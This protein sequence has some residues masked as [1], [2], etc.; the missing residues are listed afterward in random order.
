MLTVTSRVS[1]KATIHRS[2]KPVTLP[3]RIRDSL[4]SGSDRERMQAAVGLMRLAEAAQL[5]AEAAEATHASQP[6]NDG[7]NPADKMGATNES[8]DAASIEEL[9][10]LEEAT[11][12]QYDRIVS[13]LKK[14]KEHEHLPSDAGNSDSNVAQ[15]SGPAST[16]T[17]RRS[18]RLTASATAE[19]QQ[20]GGAAD[21]NKSGVDDTEIPKK[22]PAQSKIEPATTA[23]DSAPTPTANQKTAKDDDDSSVTQAVPN[24]VNAAV[25]SVV[26]ADATSA[27]DTIAGMA[28]NVEQKIDQ[29]PAAQAAIDSA[30]T[31]VSEA[32]KDSDD[33]PPA[34]IT[35]K[36][37][38]SGVE[39]PETEPN[40]PDQATSPADAMELD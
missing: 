20:S 1:R 29:D 31:P 34:V 12:R 14:R 21:R 40:V 17:P 22:S 32:N 26:G 11:R 28:A 3:R 24:I 33:Q 19:G 10:A 6:R 30:L 9:A 23:N 35:I 7:R 2:R 5:H 13:E 8:L 37:N 25:T 38:T 15:A 27:T 4:R 16:K 18:G 39:T 36:P